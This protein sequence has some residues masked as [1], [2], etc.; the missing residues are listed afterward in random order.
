VNASV[1]VDGGFS[2]DNQVLYLAGNNTYTGGT[3]ILHDGI[4]V[5]G[6]NQSAGTGTITVNSLQGGLGLNTGVT[7]TNPIVLTQGALAGFGT[8][9]PTSFNG[10]PGAP[11]T[12][13]TN[14]LIIPTLPGITQVAG[15][16]LSVTGDV[17]FADGGGYIWSLQDPTFSDGYGLVAIS[18]MLN[19]SSLSPGGFTLFLQSFNADGFDGYANLTWGAT[20][21]FTILTAA[22][23]ITG[24]NSNQFLFDAWDFQGGE[25]S[26]SEF[27]LS[28]SGN[29]LVL[30]FVAVPEPSTWA[31]LLTGSAGLGLA[32]WRRRKRA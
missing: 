29:N 32:A 14:Q 13:G 10:V 30:N 26:P 28:V 16:T 24:F 25:I 11:I 23:G 3:S 15:G 9:A 19:L 27:S 12:I 18:G 21:N 2:P 8:F 4:L 1:T 31:L 17:V 20:Y 7:L 22:G 5:L 6:A